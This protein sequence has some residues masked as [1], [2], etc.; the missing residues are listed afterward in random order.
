M[1]NIFL[2][3][4]PNC[5]S[6]RKLKEDKLGGSERYFTILKR[7]LDKEADFKVEMFPDKPNKQYDLC[8]HSNVFDPKINAKKHILFAGSWHAQGYEHADLTICVSEYFRDRMNWIKALVIPAPFDS[9][10][11]KYKNSQYM[12]HRIVTTSNPNRHLKHTLSIAKLL[13]SR[14]TVYDWCLSGG[15]KLYSDNWNDSVDLSKINFG[16]IYRGVLDRLNLLCLLTS[17]HVY[18]YAN[19]SDNSETCSVATMEAMALDIP[20]ILPKREPFVSMFPEAIFAET[21]DEMADKIQMGFQISRRDF[22]Y[23][24][25]GRYSSDV[26]F[27]QIIK[28]IKDM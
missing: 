14:N 17:A 11:L 2:S 23:K 24:D 13:Y 6:E 15:H 4:D 25:I 28:I 9:E 21:E 20:T 12:P 5:I 22:E 7:Y 19:F 8:I 3:L 10:I 26:I 1:L 18:A 27:P 16:I